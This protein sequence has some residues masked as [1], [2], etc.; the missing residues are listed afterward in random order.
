[1]LPLL[2]NRPDLL[3]QALNLAS[4]QG[5][6][7]GLAQVFFGLLVTGLIGSLQA[8]Q[9]SQSRSVATFQS[10]GGVGRIMAFL[11][12]RVV[13]VVALQRG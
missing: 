11:F 4:G 6:A 12:A 3:H 5:D 7:T 2:G 13:V 9:A 8:R 10:E 1:M